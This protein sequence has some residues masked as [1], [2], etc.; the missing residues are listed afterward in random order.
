MSISHPGSTLPALVR[1]GRRFWATPAGQAVQ[2]AERACLGP[3]CEG[4][5]G[6]HSLE[7]GM[8]EPLADMCAVRHPM[9]WAPTR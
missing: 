4:V 2:H 5:F 9:V 7:L 1:D 6:V 3:V 8:G